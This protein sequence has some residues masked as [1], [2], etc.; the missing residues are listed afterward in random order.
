MNALLL[1]VWAAL[2]QDHSVL[3]I[4]CAGEVKDDKP[5]PFTR[6][7]R[8]LVLGMGLGLTWL[9]TQ[10]KVWAKGEAA[11]MLHPPQSLARLMDSLVSSAASCA[12]NLTLGKAPVKKVLQLDWDRQGGVHGALSRAAGVWAGVV[13]GGSL[14]HVAY[15]AMRRPREASLPLVTRWLESFV[16][17]MLVA[18]PVSIAAHV[19]GGAAR[20]RVLRAIK[21]EP[22]QHK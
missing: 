15:V 20:Q 12:V 2:K 8:G 4:F 18:E 10:A 14:V 22:E 17:H 19:F 5:Q 11:G 9:V 13:A 3:G 6:T 21:G 1:D 7:E 16:V